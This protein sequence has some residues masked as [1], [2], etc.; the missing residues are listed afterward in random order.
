MVRSLIVG[1]CVLLCASAL[2]AQRRAVY[3]VTNFE[4]R[5]DRPDT[6]IVS[7]DSD[8]RFDLPFF[9]QRFRAPYY[10]PDR[11]VDSDYTSS[12]VV[13]TNLRFGYDTLRGPIGPVKTYAYDSLSRLYWFADGGCIFCSY[14]PYAYRIEYDSTGL[15]QSVVAEAPTSPPKTFRISYDEARDIKQLDVLQ[16]G[17]LTMRVRRIER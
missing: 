8:K 5:A 11:L 17:R 6:V 4:W 1:L 9:C 12:R 2:Q 3:E 15:I 10:L 13:V 7:V 16:S 14:M